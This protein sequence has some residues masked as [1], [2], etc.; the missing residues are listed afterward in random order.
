MEPKERDPENEEETDAPKRERERERKEKWKN[1]ESD[2]A[3][4]DKEANFYVFVL[5]LAPISC[6]TLIN[7]VAMSYSSRF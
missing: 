1:G 2:R 6:R 7:H 3:A 5:C 4:V